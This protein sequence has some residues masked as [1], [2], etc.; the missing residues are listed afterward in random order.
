MAPP[1]WSA[2]I[3]AAERGEYEA[4]HRGDVDEVDAQEGARVAVGKEER[5]LR[6]GPQ[7]TAHRE[8]QD[9]LD[10]TGPKV[11]IDE[12]RHE[13]HHRE[14]GVGG[15]AEPWHDAQRAD[16]DQ[17]DERCAAAPFAP[18]FGEGALRDQLQRHA[19]EHE[20][21]EEG[22]PLRE[23]PIQVEEQLAF[24]DDP[25]GS[26]PG[27]ALEPPHLLLCDEA[28]EA[29]AHESK[30]EPRD[31]EI[32]DAEAMLVGAAVAQKE[33]VNE[34]CE[35]SVD[36]AH[37]A[38]VDVAALERPGDVLEDALVATERRERCALG[39]VDDPRERRQRHDER[40]EKRASQVLNEASSTHRKE[41]S[42]RTKEPLQQRLDRAELGLRGGRRLVQSGA[43]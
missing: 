31:R 7:R 5:E 37:V 29:A 8:P 12:Q 22:L 40:N 26:G 38:V 18:V 6:D 20:P 11:A 34:V 1:H 19:R 42:S 33:H 13:L 4:V 14:D 17:Q 25:R 27:C 36:V 16:Q 10:A 28:R 23:V 15:L 30:D 24:E 9:G 43:P 21:V 3:S 2:R 35:R 39:A 32:E 41:R